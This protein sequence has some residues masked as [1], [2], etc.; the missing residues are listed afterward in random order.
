[1]YK[2][3]ALDMDGTLLDN[4]KTI[5]EENIRAIK[6]AS[7][8]GVKIVLATGRP[9][10]G[11]KKYLDILELTSE[12]NFSIIY[13]GALIQNNINKKII[14]QN[15]LNYNDLM[16]FYNLSKKF[17]IHMNVFTKDSCISYKSG[18]YSVLE[19][20]WSNIDIQIV[21]FNNLDKN[22][23]IAKIIFA[24]DPELISKVEDN[25]GDNIY[26]KYG[27]AKSAPYFMEFFNRQIN[28]GIA[29][30]KYADSLNIAKE[31]IICIGDAGNDIEMIKSA[32]LGVAMENAFPEIKDIADYTTLSNEDA[33]V[34]HVIDK[35]IL[36]KL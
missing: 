20:K 29:V 7:K 12:D 30:K 11:I 24:D 36:S 31:E 27:I 16:Y 28:K 34:A 17:D 22:I 25:L 9:L 8:S 1:M 26:S 33:G 23:E 14:S 21:D 2:L 18:K 4:N 32:G 3:V 10:V 6:E 19:A 15:L 13:N 5:P 35:F